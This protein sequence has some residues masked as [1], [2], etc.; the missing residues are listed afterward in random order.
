LWAHNQ[1]IITCSCMMT[2]FCFCHLK[3]NC[4]LW[5]LLEFEHPENFEIW[6]HLVSSWNLIESPR[7]K[8]LCGQKVGHKKRT[9]TN[10]EVH[11]KCL[12][13]SKSTIWKLCEQRKID[14]IHIIYRLWLGG[15]YNVAWIY[16]TINVPR[17]F[18]Y[19]HGK[20]SIHFLDF[21]LCFGCN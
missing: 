16:P 19:D 14:Q 15:G 21:G 2:S 12:L 20:L 7:W 6:L 4:P 11:D 17:R 10:L 9:T 1:L 13:V 8:L 5:N 18:A 3:M